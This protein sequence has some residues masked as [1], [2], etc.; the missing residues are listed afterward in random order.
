MDRH[1]TEGIMLRLVTILAISLLL[2]AFPGKRVSAAEGIN[3]NGYINV[4]IE[5]L[6]PDS[7][8]W[9]TSHRQNLEKFFEQQSN[10][11]GALL[12]KELEKTGVR[13]RIR[14]LIGHRPADF[15][16]FRE[17]GSPGNLL[18]TV[19][20][21]IRYG[22]SKSSSLA[23]C[24]SG[25][26]CFLLAPADLFSYQAH[27]DAAVSLFYYTS[28][29]R[30]LRL[31]QQHYRTTNEIS[32]DFYE[33]MS[34]NQEYQWIT[35]L[36]GDAIDEIQQQILE[37]LPKELE[38]RSWQ[39]ASE[40]L[41]N[42]R[43]QNTQHRLPPT[44]KIQPE[45]DQLTQIDKYKEESETFPAKPLN[46][47]EMLR[48]VSQSIFKVR[49]E[50][51]TGSGFIFSGGGLGITNLHVVENTEHLSVRFHDGDVAPA[52]IVERHPELDLAILRF[53]GIDKK[54]LRLGNSDRVNIADQITAIGFPLEFG[55][56]IKPGR[57]VSIEHF[58]EIP[59]F[60]FDPAVF[61]G[62]SGGPLV[63][64]QGEVVG[65][66]FARTTEGQRTTMA[67]PIREAFSVLRPYL[68]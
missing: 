62:H 23:A 56:S 1:H 6:L 14:P 15:E 49:S 45:T 51:G 34:M 54:P 27:T 63:N 52:T 53:K 50:R 33:A 26:S 9:E 35:I 11:L 18:F 10:R 48:L 57:I 8:I 55:L 5:P 42:D 29:G 36:T 40:E 32:G 47:K 31:I 16:S 41:G 64:P 67:I 12:A 28:D 37:T 59:L 44:V 38:N 25:I 65:I 43:T 17:T 46:L 39:K 13:G 22:L 58:G 3:R 4:T 68:D 19:D 60:H 7:D 21:R 2:V 20:F 24:L 30:R 61:H 66:I